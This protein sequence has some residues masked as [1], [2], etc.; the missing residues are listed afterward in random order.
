MVDL[1]GSLSFARPRTLSVLR[2][3]RAST[4]QGAIASYGALA[5]LVERLLCKQDVNGSNPLG[6]TKAFPDMTR[7]N[8]IGSVS[9][10][11]TP[12][13]FGKP[14]NIVQRDN[15]R[16]WPYPR[17]DTVRVRSFGIGEQQ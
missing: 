4:H 14:F 15:Q 12:A 1:V 3:T 5:Q 13:S 11:R 6:S 10:C 9:S 17:V 16:Y 8:R 2:A 7:E